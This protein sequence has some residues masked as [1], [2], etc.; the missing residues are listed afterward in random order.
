MNE[1]PTGMDST[2]TSAAATA[3]YVVG[4]FPSPVQ[5]GTTGTVTVSATDAF[6]NPTTG[7]VTVS[8]TD[9]AMAGAQVIATYTG[10]GNIETTFHEMRAYLGWETTRGR[11]KATVLRTAWWKTSS[12]N[13]ASK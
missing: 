7:T 6:G 1:Q 5:T 2:N 11:T 4:G 9:P 3:K 10:R 12:R 13:S 8:S